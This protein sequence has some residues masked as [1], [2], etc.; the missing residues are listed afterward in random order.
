MDSVIVTEVLTTA[1]ATGTSNQHSNLRFIAKAAEEIVDENGRKERGLLAELFSE[2]VVAKILRTATDGLTDNNPP[3]QYP[4]IVPQKGFNAGVY[5]SS[6]ISFWTCGFFPGCLY[7]LL[8][9][10]IK[11]PQG[12]PIGL[13]DDGACINRIGGNDVVGQSRSLSIRGLCNRLKSLGL[14]WSD[15]IHGEA[16]LTNTHDLGFIIMPHMRPRW[17][18]FH[19]ESAAKSIRTA[20]QSLCTRFSCTVGAIRSWDAIFWQKPPAIPITDMAENFLVIIDSMCNLDLLFYAAALTSQANL[21]DVAIKHARTLIDTHLRP[22]ST[23]RGATSSCRYGGTLYSTRHV[24][25]FDPVTGK[26]MRHMTAQGHDVSTTWSRGQAWAILGYAQTYAWTKE[27]DFLDVACGL[28]EYFLLKLETAPACVELNVRIAEQET[29]STHKTIKSG[30]YVPLW[31]FDAPLEDSDSPPL[32]DTSAGMIAANGLLM[33]SESLS[34]G[35]QH[36]LSARYIE[37]ALRIVRETIECSLAPEKAHLTQVD[38]QI[39]GEDV[40]PERTFEAIL[41]NAT[42]SNNPMG[43]E[44]IKDHGLVYA[45]YYFIEF[46]NKLLRMGVV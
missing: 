44:R 32:R 36:D 8:E 19:D 3:T 29:S 31:D 30:R 46:G 33:L 37:A 39:T 6:D 4:N 17:E 10:S 16:Q 21:A 41:K 23:L 25:N 14:L 35:G 1:S 20:A 38:G 18:L 12:I 5:Q 24:V 34:D 13:D 28:A 2:N 11:Y 9:R 42:T 15:P 27:L 40:T 22:E 7:S 45:D 43:R 26:V